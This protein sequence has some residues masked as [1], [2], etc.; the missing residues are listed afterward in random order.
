MS[1]RFFF[2]FG[3]LAE[4]GTTCAI[5]FCSHDARGTLA[6]RARRSRRPAGRNGQAPD[7][8]NPLRANMIGIR[9]GRR[10]RA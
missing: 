7:A 4:R 8:T 9:A 3:D 1:V 2:G 5:F 10:V 6:E